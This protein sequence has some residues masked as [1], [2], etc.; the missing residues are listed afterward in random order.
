MVTAGLDVWSGLQLFSRYAYPPNERG[1]CGPADH[2]SLLEYRTAGTIDGGLAQ[3]ARA[4]TG[5]W[6]YLKLMSERTGVGD[7]FHHKIVEAYW[8]GNEL[9]DRIGPLDF[10][11]SIESRFKSRVGSKWP[12]M[13]EAI[14]GGI[15]HHSFHVFV[16]YPW[17]GLLNES[18]RGEPLHI[19]DQCRI[20]WGQVESATGDQALVRSQPLTWD[21]KLLSLGAP[22][23]ETATLSMDGL[24]FTD[25]LQPG[26]W[27]SLHWT[28]VCDRLTPRQLASLRHYSARQ[29]EMTNRELAHPGPA[30]VLG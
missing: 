29:L 24:G 21:G 1:Y 6:P 18:D 8:V 20:R 26:D 15:P 14:P 30:L 7:P 25:S 9:L 23:L 28:W 2:R 17:V 3:L 5:P 19:L 13:A 11:N 10:G 16:T 27:V 22:R 4:F 12:G